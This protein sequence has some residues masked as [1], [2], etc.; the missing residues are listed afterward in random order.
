[1]NGLQPADTLAGKRPLKQLIITHQRLPVD[2][3]TGADAKRRYFIFEIE[4][5]NANTGDDYIRRFGCSP[6][7]GFLVLVVDYVTAKLL[8]AVLL[9][10]G[11]GEVFPGCTPFD[12]FIADREHLL[13]V[14]VEHR[15]TVVDFSAV[16]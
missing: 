8:L 11:F 7:P 16:Y 4:N 5:G 9:P 12:V 6:G 2:A 14:A 10:G 15:G 1:M 3:H 13:P